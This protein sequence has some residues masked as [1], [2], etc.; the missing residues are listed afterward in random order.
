M[1][2]AKALS[3]A[4]RERRLEK[5]AA[6]SGVELSQ[7]DAMQRGVV[8]SRAGVMDRSGVTQTVRSRVSQAD[9]AG[10]SQTDRA[11]EGSWTVVRSFQRR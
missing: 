10:V 4:A 9:R 11:P 7:L 3:P 5:W 6:E 8:V 2:R 1:K